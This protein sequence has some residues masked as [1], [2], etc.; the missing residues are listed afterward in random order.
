M[1]LDALSF[2]IDQS[3][4]DSVGFVVDYLKRLVI[5]RTVSRMVKISE[6]I[7]NRKKLLWTL[8]VHERTV[9][10]IGVEKFNG[11]PNFFQFHKGGDKRGSRN[12]IVILV[13]DLECD[14][15]VRP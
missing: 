2:K 12:I 13:I 3:H 9:Q 11:N 1:K 5:N 6:A 4:F 7:R 14:Q 15:K 10:G 8:N